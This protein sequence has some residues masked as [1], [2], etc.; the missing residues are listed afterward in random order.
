MDHWAVSSAFSL[1]DHHLHVHQG[2]VLYFFA[3]ER[4]IIVQSPKSRYQD[5]Q[6]SDT[7]QLLYF[8][9]PN[10]A[11]PKK[12]H[13]AAAG[14][15][16][17]D[18]PRTRGLDYNQDAGISAMVLHECGIDKAGFVL[19]RVRE[20]AAGMVRLLTEAPWLKRVMNCG[21][22][23]LVQRHVELKVWSTSTIL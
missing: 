21:I 1:V 19:D 2:F 3:V 8:A 9:V 16:H 13:G 10:V 5:Q 15:V 23:D 22:L 17:S 11:F 18:E 6:V 4:D 14:P 12:T 7:I 20:G